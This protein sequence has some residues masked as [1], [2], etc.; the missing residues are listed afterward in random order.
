MRAEHVQSKYYYTN[1]LTLT[2]MTD[3]KENHEKVVQTIVK[4]IIIYGWDLRTQTKTDI[5]EGKIQF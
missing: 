3:Q 2:D 1:S 5:T 4:L